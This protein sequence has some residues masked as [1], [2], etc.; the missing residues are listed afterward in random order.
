[1]DTEGFRLN[2][3]RGSDCFIGAFAQTWPERKP[4]SPER[5]Q[6]GCLIE[7]SS[8]LMDAFI[9]FALQDARN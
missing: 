7:W 1:M 3:Y 4:I 2:A 5:A 9:G 6:P 8:A